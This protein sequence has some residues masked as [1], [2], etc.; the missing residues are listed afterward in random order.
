MEIYKNTRSKLLFYIPFGLTTFLVVMPWGGVILNW[1][2]QSS[3]DILV[4]AVISVI[5]L[6]GPIAI[7]WML[8]RYITSIHIVG[9]EFVIKSNSLTG[10]HVYTGMLENGG[11]R[12][13]E[14]VVGSSAGPTR[15][16]Y[17]YFGPNRKWMFA[18]TFLDTSVESIIASA[19]RRLNSARKSKRKRRS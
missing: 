6:A 7:E 14:Q 10:E 16:L 18:D 17:L 15:G 8:R 5:M 12:E 9:K 3:E 11:V 4:A 19:I 2:I 1:E 13:T